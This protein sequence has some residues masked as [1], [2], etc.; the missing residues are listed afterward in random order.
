[1][2]R[3][4][5]RFDFTDHDFKMI[6]KEPG[7]RASCFFMILF[8]A[9]AFTG[10]SQ[11]DST[12]A[13]FGNAGSVY[14]NDYRSTKGSDT[15]L[16][17]V[18]NYFPR[19]VLG[20][21]GLPNQS[22]LS[23]IEIARLGIR[24]YQPPFASDLFTS[25]GPVFFQA[26]LY[27]NIFASAGQKKEQVLKM[28]HA[29]LINKKVNVALKFNRYSANGFYT[30]QLTFVNNLMF[31]SHY[32]TKSERWGYAAYL[33]YNKLKY[34]E[35]GGISND[36]LFRE[37]LFGNKLLIPV[38]LADAR[39][40]LRTMEVSATQF[41][42]L[43]KGRDSSS[44]IDHYLYYTAAYEGN[45][46]Q[47]LDNVPFSGYYSAVY[48]DS[49]KTNDSTHV[50]K[51]V[52]DGR[53]LLRQRN[54]RF[55][56]YAGYRNE[57]TQLYRRTWNPVFYN[58]IA[59]LGGFIQNSSR[60][61]K[62]N[63]E[64]EYIVHG[65]YSGDYRLV[66][67][68]R[69]KIKFRNTVFSVYASAEN[70]SPDQLNTWNQVNNFYWFTSFAK[71]KS[72]QLKLSVDLTD[73]KLR[74][75]VSVRNITNALY[76]DTLALPAQLKST[77]NVM[78]FTLGK[79]LKLWRIH[80][81]NTVNY[82]VVTDTTFMRLPQLV[83]FHQL[84]YEGDH[85]KK[86]LRLQVGFQASYISA[87]TANAYMPATNVFYVQNRQS[88]GNYP[89]VDFFINAWIK[90]VKLFFKVE[91]VN[92]GFSGPNYS[93]VPAYIQPDRAFKFGLNWLFLD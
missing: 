10:I 69:K 37:D 78:R 70:R 20:N 66:M 77:M 33:I 4:T 84:Y 50:K 81:N 24:Y 42:R 41:F 87:F 71:T 83:T 49:L 15:T 79:D 73:W 18:Q 74:A 88:L 76:F 90:P 46:Y 1:M 62:L 39:R 64:G 5:H 60:N 13:K 48:T 32:K 26:P 61:A 16:D 72:D 29:Q 58:D 57:I 21:V 91:H 53:Y 93:L 25:N 28:S 9:R 55:M 35:N 40:N 12:S 65:E 80:F 3:K 36:T 51:L 47:Y 7:I 92:Q 11:V 67:D 44:L 63:L 14:F 38:N 54:E 6:R 75:Q 2:R 27:T 86:N 45:Y 19:N 68:A 43:N 59:Q 17:N 23:D 82:Q 22:L 89:F 52:N 31:S 85:Y 56:F 8:I 30:R 34:Q